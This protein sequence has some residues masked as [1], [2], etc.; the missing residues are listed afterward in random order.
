MIGAYKSDYVRVSG[1][2]VRKFRYGWGGEDID[3]SIDSSAT[4]ILLS[5]QENMVYC[6]DGTKI[7]V[8]EREPMRFSLEERDICATAHDKHSDTV[9]HKHTWNFKLSFSQTR[10]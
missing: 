6:I 1:Y 7:V 10:L 5:D 8:E 2:N 3:L 9:E 4:A